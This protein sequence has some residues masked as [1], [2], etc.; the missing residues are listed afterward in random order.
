MA[1]FLE[2]TQAGG[3]HDGCTLHINMDLVVTMTR[4]QDNTMLLVGGFPTPQAFYVQES[5]DTIKQLLAKA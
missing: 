2:L 5:I 3:E 4:V 1:N